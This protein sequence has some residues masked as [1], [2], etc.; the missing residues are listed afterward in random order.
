MTRV[1]ER[2]A[3]GSARPVADAVDV[4]T[5]R[6]LATTIADHAFCGVSSKDN[7][8]MGGHVAWSRAGVF[9]LSGRAGIRHDAMTIPTQTK[10][11]GR[12]SRWSEP[13]RSGQR[14]GFGETA[15]GAGALPHRSHFDFDLRVPMATCS[16]KLAAPCGTALH[17][18]ATTTGDKEVLPPSLPM[19]MTRMEE[20]ALAA[21][22]RPATEGIRRA[23]PAL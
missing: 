11:D 12:V 21:V 8:V 20:V 5:T 6:R 2:S 18:V 15:A 23:N 1:C 17:Q 9:S 10:G 19:G 14:R 16:D 13:V 7:D 4:S 22:A 3:N